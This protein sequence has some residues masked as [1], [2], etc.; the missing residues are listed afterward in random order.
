MLRPRQP[1]ASRPPRG[2]GAASPPSAGREQHWVP[3]G[4]E[5]H[6]ALAERARAAVPRAAPREH[7][8]VPARQMPLGLA[9]R[10]APQ[11][12]EQTAL[13]GEPCAPCPSPAPSLPLGPPGVSAHMQGLGEAA[14]LLP[15]VWQ[16][17]ARAGGRCR[18]CEPGALLPG[19][20]GGAGRP[21]PRGPSSG[22][23]SCPEGPVSSEPR[24]QLGAL[25][26]PLG[27]HGG[28]RCRGLCGHHS[29]HLVVVR[30]GCTGSGHRVCTPPSRHEDGT[31]GGPRPSSGFATAGFRKVSQGRPGYV[32]SSA[33]RAASLFRWPAPCGE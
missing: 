22:A 10:T 2:P 14:A 12:A 25:R 4:R 31:R 27:W 33:G 5:Q 7:A 11:A 13:R 23:G 8:A 17:P 29:R 19:G 28:A 21:A 24:G 3:A 30:R 20:W 26:G 15:A 18:L 16:E 1:W 9:G 6:W 32:A